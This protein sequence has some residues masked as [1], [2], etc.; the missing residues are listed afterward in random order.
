[1]YEVLGNKIGDIAH[2]IAMAPVESWGLQMQ[3]WIVPFRNEV[4]E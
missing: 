3:L 2:S 4:E 1:M